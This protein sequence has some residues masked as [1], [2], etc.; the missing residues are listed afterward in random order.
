M[1]DIRT[2]TT[3]QVTQLATNPSDLTFGPDGRLYFVAARTLEDEG[4]YYR[5]VW[6]LNLETGDLTALIEQPN[7]LIA[8][9][10]SVSPDGTA[11]AYLAPCLPERISSPTGL[12]TVPSGGGEADAADGRT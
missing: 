5:N 6:Q 8:G 1:L 3:E 12:W 7:P 4:C 9:S 2:G 11:V 10:P